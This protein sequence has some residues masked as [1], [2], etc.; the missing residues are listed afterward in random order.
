MKRLILAA[1]FVML[2]AGSVQAAN[3]EFTVTPTGEP[4]AGHNLY[5]RAG[6]AG[7]GG[8]YAGVV[9]ID[10]GASLVHTEALLGEQ[11]AAVKA[12]LASGAT[13]AFSDEC[14]GNYPPGK[15]GVQC[16]IANP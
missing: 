13:S 6:T 2:I 7:D 10:M 12:Y 11:C 16:D 9:P 8:G 1:L 3:V 15:P 5:I 14:C 4:V